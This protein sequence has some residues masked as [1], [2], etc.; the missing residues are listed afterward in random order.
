MEETSAK[1]NFSLAG[2]NAL[3]TGAT[4][5]IGLALAAGFVRAGA[6]VTICGRKP[7]GVA[8]ALGQF[9]TS[10]EA[11]HG[12]VANVGHED[13]LERLVDEA[14]RRFGPIGVLVNNAG[15]NPFFGPVVESNATV[16]DKTLAVN[17]RAPYLLSCIVGRKM[18]AAG[19]GA[20][21]NVASVAGLTTA[22]GM[23]IYSVT[24]AGLVML[25]KVLAREW[26]PHGVR[27]NCICPGLIKTDLSKALWS[28]QQQAKL[29]TRRT[30]LGRI[31]SVEELAGAA[32]Y[33]ASDA[34]SF[35]TGAVLTVDGGMVT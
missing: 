29:F 12:V 26:G 6:N 32:V 35:T 18:I 11:V 10:P 34:S 30:P 19:S 20:V 14:E 25:T 22:P 15:T 7:E 21:I 31:G 16:W 3:V 27:V 9:E 5:G 1:E 33:L 4:R 8:T 23:G 13:D 28:D 2:K 17:L 24:K